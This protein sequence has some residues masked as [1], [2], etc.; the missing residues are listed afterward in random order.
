MAQPEDACSPLS[1][2]VPGPVTPGTGP[3]GGSKVAAIV[4][5]RKSNS[6]AA[7]CS[8]ATSLANVRD[9][10][11]DGSEHLGSSLDGLASCS[12]PD[13]CAIK[14][15]HASYWQ[16]KSALRLTV[17][18]HTQNG[19]HRS[20][21]RLISLPLASFRPTCMPACLSAC[22]PACLL[23]CHTVLMY[24]E[25]AAGPML[26]GA[27]S[28]LTDPFPAASI[29]P[30]LGEWLR[31]VVTSG[32]PLFLRLRPAPDWTVRLTAAVVWL[33]HSEFAKRNQT[34]CMDTIVVPLSRP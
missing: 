1:G 22:L 11:A 19:D 18:T 31:A 20:D 34:A 23:A 12:I 3:T 16:R 10:G 32:N 24:W 30:N 4:L 7:A 8:G 25:D 2:V 9:A 13:V 5:V 28:L 29:D 21:R 27:P 6:S 14:S 33:R 17:N 15:M 26:S